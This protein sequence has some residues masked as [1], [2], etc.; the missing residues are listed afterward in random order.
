[1]Y[2]L[3]HSTK[4]LMQLIGLKRE[5]IV[6]ISFTSVLTNGQQRETFL[7]AKKKSDFLEVQR[8]KWP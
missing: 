8:K 6:V 7:V 4:K 3:T 5:D 2:T 1:M